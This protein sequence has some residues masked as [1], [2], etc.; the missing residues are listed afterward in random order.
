M[1][2]E[3]GHLTESFN[4]IIRCCNITFLSKATDA[5]FSREVP[6]FFLEIDL[7]NRSSND[8]IRISHQEM[9]ERTRYTCTYRDSGQRIRGI[10][11]QR[12]KD[13]TTNTPE[14]S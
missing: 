5:I 12:T 10:Y 14:G 1:D 13:K 8:L 3:L 7:K 2:R 9:R 4:W 6:E 11:G